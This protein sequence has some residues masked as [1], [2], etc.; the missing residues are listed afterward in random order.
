[1]DR[2]VTECVLGLP[3]IALKIHG[4]NPLFANIWVRSSNTHGNQFV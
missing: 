3:N 2:G 4:R 1:M